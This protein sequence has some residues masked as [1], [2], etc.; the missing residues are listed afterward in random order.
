[1][2][3]RK[4]YSLLSLQN[5]RAGEGEPYRGSQ[6]DGKTR[7]CSFIVSPVITPG[8][9]GQRC[10]DEQKDTG[11][12]AQDR[13][14]C[15]VPVIPHLGAVRLVFGYMIEQH[16]VGASRAATPAAPLPAHNQ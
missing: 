12:V 6:N 7:R 5:R 11:I 13:A 16:P 15:G 3:R 9:M 4:P 8:P 1:M 10:T 14:P 2:T